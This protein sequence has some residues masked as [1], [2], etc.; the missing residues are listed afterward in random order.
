MAETMKHSEYT[1]VGIDGGASKVSGWIIN[2]I[3]EENSYNLSEHHAELP[4]TSIE[5]HLTNFKPVEIQKQIPQ[6]VQ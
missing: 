2:D 5:G 3:G 1:L 6:H 4:Y